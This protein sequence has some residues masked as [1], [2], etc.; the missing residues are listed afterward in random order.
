MVLS[1]WDNSESNA[2]M[3]GH[4]VTIYL[5]IWSSIYFWNVSPLQ[6]MTTDSV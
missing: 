3:Y 1:S 4:E 5:P 2:D 6:K